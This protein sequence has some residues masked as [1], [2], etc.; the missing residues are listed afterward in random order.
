MTV[1]ALRRQRPAPDPSGTGDPA[2]LAGQMPRSGLD[3]PERARSPTVRKVAFFTQDMSGAGAFTTVFAAYARALALAG[4]ERIDLVTVRG[5]PRSS[6][7]PFPDLAEPVSIGG[8][9]TGQALPQLVRYLEQHQPDVMIPGPIVPNLGACLARLLARRWRGRLVLSH[10]HPIRLARGQSWKNSPFLA[11]RL[12]PAAAGSFA[13]SPAV[14]EEAIAVAGL[15]PSRVACIPV[16][17]APPARVVAAANHHPWLGPG[18]PAGPLFVSV[19]RLAPE[20]NL[21]VLIDAFGQIEAAG[22]RLLIVGGGPL[23]ASLRDAVQARGLADRIALTGQVASPKPFYEAADV[24][25]S[26]SEEEGFGLVLIEAMTAGLPV[27]STDAL[28][29]GPRFIL[30][31]GGAGILVGRGD[32]RA[33]AAAMTRMCDPAARAGVR[34]AGRRRLQ[35]FE[36]SAIGRELLAFLNLICCCD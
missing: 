35:A 32:A 3:R 10:H 14:R 18:R 4:I 28:G 8:G 27:I 23:E 34:D 21:P 20:K 22:A 19:G 24:F 26:A 33:L 6:E 16:P 13:V 7:V 15:E 9:H 30:D 36:P 17:M 5:D 25:V 29:G 12:Y 2:S 11:R 1:R 31:Q